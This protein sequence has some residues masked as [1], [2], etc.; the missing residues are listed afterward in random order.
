MYQNHGIRMSSFQNLKLS[1]LKFIMN[2]TSTVPQQ[3]IS[4]SLLLYIST[5]MAIRCPQNL[6]TFNFELMHDG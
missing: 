2:N 5:E 4:A 6:F 1:S 3:H